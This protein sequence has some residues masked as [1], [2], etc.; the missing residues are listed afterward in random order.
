MGVNCRLEW[1]VA[2]KEFVTT[3]VPSAKRTRFVPVPATRHYRAGISY[4]AATRLV[5]GASRRCGSILSV[6]ANSSKLRPACSLFCCC[7]WQRWGSSIRE[8]C[9]RCGVHVMPCGEDAREVRAFGDGDFVR[10]VSRDSDVGRHNDGE[11]VDAHAENMLRVP[12]G[13]D[14]V[15]GA[16]ARGER[17]VHRLS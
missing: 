15:A 6:V 12:S 8:L 11:P 17:S 2:M 10:C 5:L 16:C 1:R 9:P 14:S 13:V 4:G 7:P 3:L